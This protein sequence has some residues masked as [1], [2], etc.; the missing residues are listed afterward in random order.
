[1]LVLTVFLLA[2]GLSSFPLAAEE[3]E[4]DIRGGFKIATPPLGYPEYT[5]DPS[6]KRHRVNVAY[7]RFDTDSL[8][9]HG[10]SL[11]VNSRIAEGEW[12]AFSVKYGGFYATGQELDPVQIWDSGS[13]EWVSEGDYGLTVYGPELEALLEAPLVD[14]RGKK[15]RGFKLIPFGR[16]DAS[17]QVF[18]QEF[19]A[20]AYSSYIVGG[21]GG[22]QAH[23]LGPRGGAFSPFLQL[24]VLQAVSSDAD[25][26][27]N[28]VAWPSYGFDVLLGGFSLSGIVQPMTGPAGIYT[29]SFGFA[30]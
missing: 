2:C 10:A 9:M 23:F 26:G 20:S 25:I 14:R 15:G 16:L 19:R 24:S 21:T 8:D 29:L 12:G 22:L 17:L 18:D 3:T 4:S 27:T 5:E 30:L 13:G 1:L 28:V 7:L 6:A 11:H